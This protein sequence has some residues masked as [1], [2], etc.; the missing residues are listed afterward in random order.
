MPRATLADP[1]LDVFH[2]WNNTRYDLTGFT[3]RLVGTATETLDPGTIVR[4][5]VDAVWGDVNGDGQVGLSDIFSTIPVS[6]DGKEIR[7][8]GGVIPV[9]GGLPTST[10]PS[11]TTRPNWR[12]SIR[13]SSA[14]RRC[15]SPARWPWRAS[16]P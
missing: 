15:P 10:C 3:L 1:E 8:E 6:A 4:G 7:F 9:A 13:S 5:P 14:C 2:I 16:V 12:G 11:A